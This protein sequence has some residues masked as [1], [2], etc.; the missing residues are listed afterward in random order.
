MSTDHKNGHPPRLSKWLDL[1]VSPL[2]LSDMDSLYRAK[3]G[4]F[5]SRSHM[6]RQALREGMM[7]IEDTP[8][9]PEGPSRPEPPQGAAGGRG[10]TWVRM[11]TVPKAKLDQL[12]DECRAEWGPRKG[13]DMA[14]KMRMPDEVDTLYGGDLQA[15]TADLMSSGMGERQVRREL[16]D[17]RRLRELRAKYDDDHGQPSTMLLKFSHD[18]QP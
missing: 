4:L 10:I 13:L 12:L 5:R 9:E 8:L 7:L 2:D 14:I 16:A 11:P 3:R 18:P 17:I 1:R 6:V 15:F